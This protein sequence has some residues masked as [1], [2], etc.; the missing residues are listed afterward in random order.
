MIENSIFEYSNKLLKND[1][2][3]INC[4]LLNDYEIFL[5]NGAGYYKS[6]YCSHNNYDL[7]Y[8]LKNELNT[9]NC[10]KIVWNK[11]YKYDEPF[12]TPI[13]CEIIKNIENDFKIEVLETR[14]NYYDVNDWKPMHQDSHAFNG[15]KKENYTIGVSLGSMRELV[16][17]HISSNER[18]SF[19][20]YNGDVFCFNSEVNKKFLHGVMPINNFNKSIINDRISVIVWGIKHDNILYKSLIII[21]DNSDDNKNNDNKENNIKKRR[22]GFNKK[23]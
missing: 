20:Q 19:P 4:N 9:H 10:E 12:K 2:A 17:Q 8:K 23:K 7:F 3:K 5:N 18:F 16:F 22:W 6:L 14:L 13:F 15:N 21:N 11:H 1:S